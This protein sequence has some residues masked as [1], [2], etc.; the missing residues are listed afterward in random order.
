MKYDAMTVEGV[1][2]LVKK[3]ASRYYKQSVALNL[4]SLEFADIEQELW[5]TWLK[6]KEGFDSENEAKSG[7]VNY[8]ANA[9][10]FNLQ[11]YFRTTVR[12]TIEIAP[13]SAHD[14]TNEEGEQFEPDFFEVYHLDPERQVE[15]RQELEHAIGELSPITQMVV[16]LFLSPSEDLLAYMS[17]E[18]AHARLSGKEA[19]VMEPTIRKI[20]TY[21]QIPVSA[22][23]TV[24]EELDHVRRRIEAR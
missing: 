9:A 19:H 1:A 10:H 11:R 22:L 6:C 7:F 8:F 18:V 14:F 5:V 24:Y 15:G 20:G 16:G 23:R 3:L 17:A 12:D 21:L 4:R 2:L 13:V